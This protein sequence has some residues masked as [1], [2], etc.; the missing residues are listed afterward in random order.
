MTL[1]FPDEIDD[2]ETF[3][4]IND[5]VNGVVPC[6]EYVDDMLAMSMSQIKEIAPPEL[7]LPFDLFGVSVLEIV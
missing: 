6:D 2:H 3:V 7:A 5:I 1:C 4:E